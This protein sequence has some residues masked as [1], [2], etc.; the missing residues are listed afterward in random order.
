MISVC[1]SGMDGVTFYVNEATMT[2]SNRQANFH[3]ELQ[4]LIMIKY[5][6]EFVQRIF[7]FFVGL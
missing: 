4:V 2:K 7:N 6:R 1:G 5:A 3:K